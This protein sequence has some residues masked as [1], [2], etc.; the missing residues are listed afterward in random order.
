LLKR[1][2]KCGEWKSATSKYFP[3]DKRN[4]DKLNSWCRKCVE[5]YKKGYRKT[6]KG[7]ESNKRALQKN[8]YGITIKQRKDLY[9]KQ[10]GCCV[11]CKIAVPYDEIVTD[12]NHKT[13]K[14]RGLLCRS[15]NSGIGMLQDNIEIVYNAFCYLKK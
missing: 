4:K 8:R 10:N 14:I 5:K 9:V 1:C 7:K 12:H 3:P 15:C 11:I 13:N 6:K 2:T